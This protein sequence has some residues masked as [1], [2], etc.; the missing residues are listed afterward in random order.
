M[1]RFLYFIPKV[2]LQPTPLELEGV[3]LEH[4]IN[5]W[6]DYVG[7]TGPTGEGGAIV[8]GY[9]KTKNGVQIGYYPKKQTWTECNNGKFWIGYQTEFKP[10]AK[11][12]QKDD[13]LEG[14]LVVM[15]DKNEWLVPVARRF[16]SGDVLPQSLYL[17]GGGNLKGEILQEFIHFSKSAED[18][19][20]DLCVGLEGGPDEDYRVSTY[21]KM[22]E[23]ASEAL[24][25]NYHISKWEVSLLRLLTTENA[26]KINLAII[27]FTS[28]KVLAESEELIKKKVDA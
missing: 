21:P 11:D 6:Q 2:K 22:F 8:G 27:D 17:D 3:G 7:S 16:D 12:L 14:H 18:V 20:N 4:L 15:A 9:Y 13:Q 1:S 5:K 25:I 26:T 24:S 10:T 23:I 28:M 19:F